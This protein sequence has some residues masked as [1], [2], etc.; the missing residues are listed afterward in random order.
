MPPPR[1]LRR[2]RLA[3]GFD[4]LTMELLLD[5]AQKLAG[6]GSKETSVLEGEIASQRRSDS[7]SQGSGEH[8][9]HHE[10]V[11]HDPLHWSGGDESRQQESEIAPAVLKEVK[12]IQEVHHQGLQGQNQASQDSSIPMQDHPRRASSSSEEDADDGEG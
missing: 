10:T 12:Q 7:R 1:P 3:L 4:D 6:R 8:P 9:P 5:T 11:E 2:R